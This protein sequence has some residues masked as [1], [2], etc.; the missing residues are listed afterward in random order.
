MM[1]IQEAEVWPR[2]EALKNAL[3]ARLTAWG[4]PLPKMIFVAPGERILPDGDGSTEYAWVR[5]QRAYESARFPTPLTPGSMPCGGPLA[6]EVE[7]GVLRCAPKVT[8]NPSGSISVPTP[9]SQEAS[10]RL[11]LA[12]RAAMVEA[13]RAQSGESALGPYIAVGP[14]ANLVGGVLTAF[15]EV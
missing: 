11:G 5:L 7:I 3:T 6:L 2:L 4:Y 8:Q 10:A 15:V 12:D 9:A 1:A 14:S 13:V